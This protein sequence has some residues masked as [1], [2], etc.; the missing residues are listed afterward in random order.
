MIIPRGDTS[1]SFEKRLKNDFGE[2]IDLSTVNDVLFHM[3]DENYNTIVD[4]NQS[5]GNVVINNEELGEVSYQWQSG[6]T[7]TIGTYRAEFVVEFSDG[8]TRTFPKRD[9]YIVNV[10][11]EI[12][13]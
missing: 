12:N 9:S 1:P 2:V 7:D 4:D 11:E 13:D 8:T 6:D 3:R 10:T 5:A